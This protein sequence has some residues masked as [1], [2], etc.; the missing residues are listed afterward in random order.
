MMKNSIKRI[1]MMLILLNLTNI[2]TFI[3]IERSIMVFGKNNIGSIKSQGS[4]KYINLDKSNNSN[5][6]YESKLTIPVL[7]GIK[8]KK[9]EKSINDY[10]KEKI[11]SLDRNLSMEAMKASN[12]S[13]SNKIP[14]NKYYL[15]TDV[16]VNLCN[17]YI[18]SYNITYYQYSGGA[19]GITYVESVNLDLINS[20]KLNLK[21]IFKKGVDYKALINTR[22]KED[23][24]KTPELY[25]KEENLGFKGI[26]NNQEFYLNDKG[27]VIYFSL[28]EI[29]PYV[30]GIPEFM[31]SY[32]DYDLY[33]NLAK[34]I[35]R[36]Y[37]YIYN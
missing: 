24:S 3:G 4:C 2:N 15:Q 32:A 30:A 13:K 6:Y 1:A 16:Q 29:A 17:D 18:L 5:E 36:N 22:I 11:R 21:D 25:F 8:D 35:D 9:L 19:H 10:F 34:P 26:K 7:I 14:F 20:K 31:F 37:L 28:Y 23:I 27:L 33:F 12:Y